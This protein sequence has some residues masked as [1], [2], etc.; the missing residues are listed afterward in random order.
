M[1]KFRPFAVVRGI[2]D[3]ASAVALKLAEAGYA[4]LLAE[5]LQPAVTR[6]GQSFADAAFDGT[7]HFEGMRCRRV[8]DAAGWL[9]DGARDIAC[10]AQPLEALLSA[11]QPEVLVDARMRKRAM[12]E[13]QRGL[14]PLVIGLG[15]NFAA[16]ENCDL[17]V[18]TGWGE[19][20]GRVVEAGPTRALTGE[21]RPVGGWGRERYVY[22]PVAGLFRTALNIGEAVCQG[23][24]VAHI[25]D[26][27]VAAPRSGRL[28]G[29]VHD[30]VFV[31]AGAKCIEVVPEG[32]RFTGLAE[33]PARIAQGVIGAILQR[34]GLPPL[35]LA[36]IAGVLRNAQSGEMPLFAATLGFDRRELRALAAD[37][38]VA[39]QP[40]WGP[41]AHLLCAS[42]TP[43]L[44]APLTQLLLAHRAPGLAERPARWLAHAVAAA[45]FGHRHLWQDLGL[46]GRLEVSRLLGLCFPALAARN[47]RDLKWKRFLFLALGER[48]GIPDLSPPGCGECESHAA[49]FS[50]ALHTA[51][52]S[53]GAGHF[54]S[55][56][57][58]ET[59][60]A[61]QRP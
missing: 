37:I 6:R 46:S 4:V 31:A 28:R 42:Q 51:C 39:A 1:N 19:D 59:N 11:L 48:V 26:T 43:P 44:F 18:E 47:T 33:R 56:S 15:P 12:P 14:A 8:E 20:L 36:A 9:R 35:A 38:P 52:P 25:G 16:G 40:E 58:Q 49:C 3:V 27:P 24:T 45:G 29:L 30:G 60:H 61:H 13:G 23:Q 7:A 17:A 54:P 53:F 10:C 21:P 22:A 34:G 2:N 41:D 32:A 50:P 5:A 55:T 57:T